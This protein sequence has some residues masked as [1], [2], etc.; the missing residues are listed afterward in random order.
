MEN[1]KKGKNVELELER[2]QI[3]I[4]KLPKDFIWMHVRGGSKIRNLL[5]YALEKFPATD[6][7]VWTGYGPAVGKTIT[8]AEI[9]KRECGLPVH[10]ITKIC[11][12]EIDEYWDPIIPELDQL[13]VKRK[14]PMIHIL[15]S[16]ER[17]NDDQLGYQA[18][19]ETVTFTPMTTNSST[20]NGKQNKNRNNKQKKNSK[21]NSTSEGSTSGPTGSKSPKVS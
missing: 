17:I 6:S 14:L 13:V 4:D 15:L 11:Y 5:T 10:Q 1:Y 16:K 20:S 2:E 3:P 7:L 8:C 12:R 21:K 19:G 9:M 18:P